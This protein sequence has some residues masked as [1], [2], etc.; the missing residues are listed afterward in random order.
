MIPIKWSAEFAVVTLLAIA[1]TQC[2]E[3]VGRRRT[4][5]PLLDMEAAGA[6]TT[7]ATDIHKL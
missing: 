3:V 6:M 4:V 5:P 2:A 1:C 7:L